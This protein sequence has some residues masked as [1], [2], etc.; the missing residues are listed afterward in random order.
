MLHHRFVAAAAAV[1]LA[2]GFTMPAK[3]GQAWQS[4]FAACPPTHYV[5]LNGVATVDASPCG[6]VAP[7]VVT[8]GWQPNANYTVPPGTNS[9]FYHY[10][11]P[12]TFPVVW[13]GAFAF[14]AANGNQTQVVYFQYNGPRLDE[15]PVSYAEWGWHFYWPSGSPNPTQITFAVNCQ[16]RQ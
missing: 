9:L 13:S 16:T 15:T 7:A 12:T 4:M 2:W 1:L 5:N 11:C 14:S 6:L 3:A 10:A 8:V